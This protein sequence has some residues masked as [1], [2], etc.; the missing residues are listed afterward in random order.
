MS[1]GSACT[2]GSLEPSHVLLA[3]GLSEHDAS[4]TIRIS[5]SLINSGFDMV[6]AA[7]AIAE[8]TSLL[9]VPFI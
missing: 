1:A 5:M 4:C 6:E 9:T 8:C 2:A 7:H 3:L